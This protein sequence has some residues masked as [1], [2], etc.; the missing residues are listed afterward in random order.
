V[1]ALALWAGYLAWY[2]RRNRAS[3]AAGVTHG[4]VPAA[5]AW[6]VRDVVVLLVLNGGM[7]A[8]VLGGIFLHWD[9]S[10]FTA[11]FILMC[12][13]GGL[14]GGLGWRGTS[15]QISLGFMRLTPVCVL[16]GLARAVSAVLSE[17][18]VLDTIANALFSPLQHLP[19]SVSAMGAVVCEFALATLIP[20]ESGRA[21]V[22]LP[23]LN[24]LADMLGMSRQVMVL[25]Y[26]SSVLFGC[27]M[28]PTAGPMLAMLALARVSYGKWL[29]FMALPMALLFV[30]SMVQVALAVKM[31]IH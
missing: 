18:R 27:M 14:G 11:V 19:V 4:A 1:I 28:V 29:R 22:S 31:E 23:V 20:S 3:D 26:Q 15:A 8:I 21:L 16:I 2:T 30:L 17:G 6:K 13:L 9:L 5:G 24:P 25:A 10:D 7:G 12:F